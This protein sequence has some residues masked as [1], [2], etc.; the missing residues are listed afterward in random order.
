VELLAGFVT[1][2]RYEPGPTLFG[3]VATMLVAE[4]VFTTSVLLPRITLGEVP[5]LARVTVTTN[6]VRSTVALLIMT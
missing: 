4:A 1:E 5:K 2:S 6:V 3:I